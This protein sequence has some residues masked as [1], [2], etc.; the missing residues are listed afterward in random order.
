V[1]R[2]E[3]WFELDRQMEVPDWELLE[4]VEAFVGPSVAGGSDRP[5]TAIAD[6][7]VPIDKYNASLAEVHAAVQRSE[8]GV[9]AVRVLLGPDV[10]AAS[11]VRM[12][13]YRG[14]CRVGV[15]AA[16]ESEALVTETITRL[17]ELV[18]KAVERYAAAHPDVAQ[19]K[20][21]FRWEERTWNPPEPALDRIRAYLAR[22]FRANPQTE[23]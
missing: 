4:A 6:G 22:V 8:K 7:G 20:T 12:Y 21:E 17:A 9:W 23:E 11:D 14:H 13:L 3:K 16:A 19:G 18:A 10:P 1:S 15:S 2:Y 5:Y